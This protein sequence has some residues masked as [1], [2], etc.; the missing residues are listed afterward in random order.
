[1]G[2]YKY[3]KQ[4]LQKEYATRS[5]EYRARLT[6]WGKQ[7]T[8]IRV[9][10]PTNLARARELGYKARQ[11]VVIVRVRVRRGRRKREKADLGRKPG[12][13]GRFFSPGKSL[14]RIA[15]ERANI[16]YPN[17]EV[18]NSYWVGATGQDKYF[19]VI[20]YDRAHPANKDMPKQVGRVFRGLTHSGKKGRSL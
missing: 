12:K 10:K 6:S 1:M 14:Q 7:P 4:T 8:T 11:G 17:C 9:E 15:E 19:E 20:L 13:A 16:H 18:L 5:P 2:M 3:I